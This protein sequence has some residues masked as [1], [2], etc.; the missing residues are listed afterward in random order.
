MRKIISIFL[1]C[2]VFQCKE[3]QKA[4]LLISNAR[5]Y[6]ADDSIPWAEAMVVKDGRILAV[7]ESEVLLRRF[8]CSEVRDM[9]GFFIMPGIIEGH[10]HFLSLGGS[11]IDLNLINTKSWAEVIDSVRRHVLTTPPGHWIIGRG[12]HQEKWNDQLLRTFAGYPYND[13]LSSVSPDNPVMLTHA[14]GH[15]LIANQKAMS[16]AGIST[17]SRTPPGGRIVIDLDHQMTGIFEENAMDL[18]QNAFDQFNLTL[19]DS[20]RESALRFKAQSAS[21]KALEYGITSFQDAGSSILELRFIE[22]ACKERLIHQRIYAMLYE[23]PDSLEQKLKFLPWPSAQPDR[24]KCA[25]V[26]MYMDGALGSYGAWLMEA[27]TDQPAF[28]GQNLVDPSL[29]RR[30]AILAKEKNLQLCVHAIGDR[31][32]KEVL[33][34]ME[35]VLKQGAENQDRRWRIEHAQH[36]RREDIARLKSLGVIAS[37]QAIHCTSDAPFV[38]K[39]LGIDRA[40]S[41]SYIWRSLID[42]GVHLANG[43]DTPVESVNPFACIFAAVTRRSIG[44]KEAFFPEECMHRDEALKSYTIWNAY[45]SFDEKN[46]GSIMPGKLAD[47]IVLDRNLATCAVDSIPDTKVLEVYIDGKKVR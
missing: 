39:R 23:Q 32:N 45:A 31:G 5:I 37:M 11:L 3:T 14:S 41:T 42:N 40:R 17:E 47:F 4:D 28:S 21:A 12:W 30:V 6:T 44:Q 26:K 9:H 29:V 46:K 20:V 19:P 24:F 38:I 1:I 18:I 10:G 25:A 16:M 43:T 13:L 15:A 34:V 7:G 36:L 2:S 35:S 22:K 33:D 8:M 27:Y